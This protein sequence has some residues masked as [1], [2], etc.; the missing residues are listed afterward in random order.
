MFSQMAQRK[1][2][3]AQPRTRQ[4][5]K[6]VGAG[7]QWSV[8]GGQWSVGARPLERD[9][10]EVVRQDPVRVETGHGSTKVCGSETS[11][12]AGSSLW[13]MLFAN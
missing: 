5:A 9:A 12:H 11:L 3:G 8:A 7:E 10:R 1:T 13:F 6:D 2:T 4:E